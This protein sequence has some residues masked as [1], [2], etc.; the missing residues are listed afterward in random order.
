MKVEQR[1]RKLIR[2]QKL[3]EVEQRRE[4]EAA[5][6]LKLLQQLSYDTYIKKVNLIKKLTEIE[7]TF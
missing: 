1:R 7:G 2:M 5:E 3:M 6:K 4:Q